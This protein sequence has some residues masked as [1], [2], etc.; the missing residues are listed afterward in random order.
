[1]SNQNLKLDKYVNVTSSLTS[2]SPSPYAF[3]LFDYHHHPTTTN[4][5]PRTRSS[6]SSDFRSPPHDLSNPI[7][8][9]FTLEDDKAT[10]KVCGKRITY[11]NNAYVTNLVTHL[12]TRGIGHDTSETNSK[13][14]E[15]I[16]LN[17]LLT[18]MASTVFDKNQQQMEE[19]TKND[20]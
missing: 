11:R 14:R 7:W 15:D 9:Y 10:C 17:Y 4:Y 12:R 6:Q 13:I 3:K 5:Y 16:A 19:E 18:N 20:D 8:E 1:M 2:S